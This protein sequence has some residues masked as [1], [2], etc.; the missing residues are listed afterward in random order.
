M[1]RLT[2]K[3]RCLLIDKIHSINTKKIFMLRQ[4]ISKEINKH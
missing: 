4:Y 1:L 2:F 3:K